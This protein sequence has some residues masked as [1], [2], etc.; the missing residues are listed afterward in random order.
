MDLSSIAIGSAAILYGLYLAY[1]RRSSPESLGKL[2]AMKER[3]GPVAG[4]RIH[5]VAYTGLPVALGILLIFRGV[6][7]G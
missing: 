6:S 4:S 2:V 5:L 3:W 7:G 1:A